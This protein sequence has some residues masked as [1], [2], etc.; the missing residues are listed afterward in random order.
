MSMKKAAIAAALAI[1]AGLSACAALDAPRLKVLQHQG[2]PSLRRIDSRREAGFRQGEARAQGGLV[3]GQAG[4]P[5][6][7]KDGQF[8]QGFEV[9]GSRRADN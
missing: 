8:H 2:V 4:E 9:G 5:A 3:F 7:G 6:T 1:A